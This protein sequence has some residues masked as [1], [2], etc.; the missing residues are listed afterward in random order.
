MRDNPMWSFQLRNKKST[1]PAQ[2]VGGKFGTAHRVDQHAMLAAVNPTAQQKDEILGATG[3]SA[4]LIKLV[5]V[6]QGPTCTW[7]QKV[8]A[9]LGVQQ[10]LN[11]LQSAK[12]PAKQPLTGAGANV[13]LERYVE[14][15]ERM[16][17]VAAE[18]GTLVEALQRFDT[19]EVN[20]PRMLNQNSCQ[21]FNQDV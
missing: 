19:A 15:L 9:L 5:S 18:R 21:L 17:Q 6:P 10:N 16:Q 4:C 3:G 7:Q 11:R 8:A 1:T 13:C 2:A 14:A 20:R 12:V